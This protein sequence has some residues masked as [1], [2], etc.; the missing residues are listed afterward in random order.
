ME[1]LIETTNA[2]VTIED[3]L[4]TFKSFSDKKKMK[5]IKDAV[6][7]IKHPDDLFVPEEN[8]ATICKQIEQL[9]REDKALGNESFLKYKDGK[10]SKRK[11]KG[12]KNDPKPQQTGYIGTGGECAVISELLFA[13]YN[14]NRMMLDEGVDIIATKDNV[15]YYIQVKTTFINDGKIQAQIPLD[16]FM[17]NQNINYVIVARYHKDG[18]WNNMFFSFTAAQISQHI[19]AKC[20]KKGVENISIKIKFHPRSGEPYLYDEKEYPCSHNWNKADLLNWVMV[21]DD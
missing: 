8:I 15:Y 21:D 3:I 12:T 10:Y 9:I 7:A 14:A 2:D 20:I 6:V 1:E 11:N 13:G 19:S 17:Q 16:R 5:D 4:A 18:A